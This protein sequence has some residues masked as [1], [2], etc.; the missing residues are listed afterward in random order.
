MNLPPLRRE[1]VR[2]I[3]K[4][5]IQ[6]YG[7]S[8]LV[9]MENAG[10][11]AAKVVHDV[12]ATGQVT[13]LCGKGNNA[14]DG[15]V[16]ARHLELM[17][18]NVILVSLVPIEDLNGDAR[19]N[20]EIAKR[21]GL[22]IKIASDEATLRASLVGAEVIVD[23][24]LGTGAQGKLRF[25]YEVAVQRANEVAAVRIAMDLPTGMDCN[26]GEVQE[27]TFQ[28]DH[29]ITFV[30]PKLGFDNPG[31]KPFLGRVHIV[32]IGAPAKLLQKYELR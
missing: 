1:Q 6:Q 15:Y 32:G 11:G 12:A 31:A 7:I 2:E 5:A 3:D 23:C 20:A 10:A 24:L 16:I 21:S 18:R 29:T 27:S 19:V 30:A 8:G 14:G 17:G 25:P 28:A 26:S 13:I 22:P 9:L 4:I